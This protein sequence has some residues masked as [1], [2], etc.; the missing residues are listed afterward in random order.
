MSVHIGNISLED[1]EKIE[2]YLIFESI[3]LYCAQ[4]ELETLRQEIESILEEELF[5]ILNARRNRAFE[6]EFSLEK[7]D[8][9][10]RIYAKVEPSFFQ[11]FLKKILHS[12]NTQTF[13][14]YEVFNCKK[15]FS[16][17]SERTLLNHLSQ[18]FNLD[19]IKPEIDVCVNVGIKGEKNYTMGMFEEFINPSI[20]HYNILNCKNFTN[21]NSK[22]NQLKCNKNKRKIFAHINGISKLNFYC[23]IVN[24]FFSKKY[25]N[26][27]YPIHSAAAT[28]NTIYDWKTEETLEKKKKKI[29]HELDIIIEKFTNI[30]NESIDI[31]LEVTT[32]ITNLIGFERFIEFQLDGIEIFKVKTSIIK[33]SIRSG[34]ES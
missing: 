3:V 27:N 21:Y 13:L 8:S 18:I 33:R 1:G 23:P 10:I 34:L 16:G 12:T 14:Y 25:R 20:S 19:I 30:I 6:S 24:Q 32:G 28:I 31:R 2:I 22:T 11:N 17:R 15:I 5:A 9:R 26:I 7:N 4:E 29:Y